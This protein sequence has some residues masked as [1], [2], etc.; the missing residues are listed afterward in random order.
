MVIG[1]FNS[2]IGRRIPGEESAIE[3]FS[4]ECRVLCIY[5]FKPPCGNLT[6]GRRVPTW[7]LVL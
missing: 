2:K 4:Y 5:A 7:S 3:P 6:V 1:D